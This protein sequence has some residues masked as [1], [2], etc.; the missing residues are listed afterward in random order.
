MPQSSKSSN[1]LSLLDSP[2]SHHGFPASFSL[3]TTGGL[4]FPAAVSRKQ[5]LNTENKQVSPQVKAVNFEINGLSPKNDN[6]SLRISI[7]EN[8][9]SAARTSLL[10]L[11]KS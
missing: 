5:P 6:S 11:V 2:V 9:S 1:S 10:K 4:Y 8:E 3:E 7:N